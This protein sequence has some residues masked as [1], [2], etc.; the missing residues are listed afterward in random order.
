MYEYKYNSIQI[1]QI[2]HVQYQE[3]LQNQHFS[4]KHDLRDFAVEV[5]LI[6][7]KIK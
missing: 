5:Y 3:I 2:K 6:Q 7:K 1:I 4:I